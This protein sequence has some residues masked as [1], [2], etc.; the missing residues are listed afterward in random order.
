[1]GRFPS[2]YVLAA[3]LLS[4]FAPAWAKIKTGPAVGAHIPPF[5]AVD[6]HGDLRNFANLTGPNGL[7][8]LFV[9]SADW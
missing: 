1:M 4:A 7:V 5:E 9:R 6:T 8:L 2:A 3:L